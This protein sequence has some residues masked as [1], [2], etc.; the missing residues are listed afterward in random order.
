MT[1]VEKG[2]FCDSCQKNIWDLSKASDAELLDFFKDKPSNVCGKF[3]MNQLDRK[4]VPMTNKPHSRAPWIVAGA[5][6]LVSMAASAQNSADEDP[7]HLPSTCQV[8][9][10][11]PEQSEAMD[12]SDYKLAIQVLDVKYNEGLPAAVIILK[13]NGEPMTMTSTDFDGNGILDLSKINRELGP[14][15]LEIQSFGMETMTLKGDLI[16]LRGKSLK[17]ELTAETG[18]LGLVEIVGWVKPEYEGEYDEEHHK[19]SNDEHTSKETK[20]WQFWK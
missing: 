20:W 10:M 19:D 18:T 2:R 1:P 7:K 13:Q 15:E 17:A 16:E 3:S 4:I 6:S 5:F 14:L 8:I 12:S 11:T 9:P